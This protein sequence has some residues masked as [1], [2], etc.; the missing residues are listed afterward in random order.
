MHSLEPESVFE[1][2]EEAGE[3]TSLQG[4]GLSLSLSL[5]SP[6]ADA[7]SFFSALLFPTELQPPAC[8]QGKGRAA[9]SG[10]KSQALLGAALVRLHA[11]YQSGRDAGRRRRGEGTGRQSRSRAG[12]NRLSMCVRLGEEKS[13]TRNPSL[14]HPKTHISMRQHG[15]G[16]P[17]RATLHSFWYT[18]NPHSPSDALDCSRVPPSSVRRRRLLPSLGR[19][20]CIGKETRHK[21]SAPS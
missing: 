21:P 4:P 11:G 13:R 9:L 17:A 10:S 6:A 16:S 15:H 2:G 7:I 20:S 8:V 3:E 1:P 14:M 12:C 19:D 18:R 5:T